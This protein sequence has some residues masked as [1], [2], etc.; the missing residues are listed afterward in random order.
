MVAKKFIS[1]ILFFTLLAPTLQQCSTGKQRQ[2]PAASDTSVYPPISVVVGQAGMVSTMTRGSQRATTPTTTPSPGAAIASIIIKD[3]QAS[4][5]SA[6][7]TPVVTNATEAASIAVI[8]PKPVLRRSKSTSPVAR[9]SKPQSPRQPSEDDAPTTALE[10][11]NQQ[12]PGPIKPTL[13][14]DAAIND[15][16]SL[17]NSDDDVDSNDE[18]ATKNANALV[19]PELLI[20]RPFPDTDLGLQD[21]PQVAGYLKGFDIPMGWTVSEYLQDIIKKGAS[22]DAL[23]RKGDEKKFNNPKILERVSEAVNADMETLTTVT[24]GLSEERN[25]F[26]KEER[27]ALTA[28]LSER[29]EKITNFLRKQRLAF[30]QAMTRVDRLLA[31][32]KLTQTKTGKGCLTQNLIEDQCERLAA[33]R[34]AFETD[35]KKQQDDSIETLELQ[36]A[37]ILQGRQLQADELRAQLEKTDALLRA[38]SA[39]HPLHGT[40]SRTE[41]TKLSSYQTIVEIMSAQSTR[42]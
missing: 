15:V 2:P 19:A 38:L 33:I 6:Q 35:S 17:P 18:D 3:T 16:T 41:P 37:F 12:N 42:K 22:E 31:M 9:T 10:P 1:L 21:K 11:E 32:A 20:G 4:K 13:Q 29:E 39:L 40:S 34:N 36:Y 26:F 28:F 27:A 23:T 8:N 14:R 7:T 5:D 30:F 24:R 25:R